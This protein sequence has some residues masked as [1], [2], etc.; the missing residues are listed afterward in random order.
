MTAEEERDRLT[1]AIREA[2]AFESILP[3]IATVPRRI[4]TEALDYQ[5]TG[6]EPDR[7]V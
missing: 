1:A 4:L 3:A 6:Q 7:V 2:L 5:P